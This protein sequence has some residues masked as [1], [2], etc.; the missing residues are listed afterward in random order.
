MKSAFITGANRG[1]G[2]G[3]VEHLLDRGWRVFGGVRTKVAT[4]PHHENLVWIEIDVADDASIG[5]AV[6]EVRQHVS[7]LD[8]LINNAGVNKDTA[9]QHHKER[10]SMLGSLERESLQ[11]IFDINSISPLMVLQR[12]LPLLTPDPSFVI[13]VSSR[14]ASFQNEFENEYAN[15]GYRAS[16]VA[17]NMITACSVQD[18]PKNIRTF[19]VHPGSVRTD[20]NPKGTD[21][22]KIQAQKIVTITESWNDDW[23]GQFMKYDGILYSV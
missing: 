8:L 23:N 15:Y 2:Y 14:R 12:F 17:L 18:L 20:M 1:L 11:K 3:F 5:R 7:T 6:A 9:T 22:P 13:Q 16:K 10:V 4:L 19:S 21:E